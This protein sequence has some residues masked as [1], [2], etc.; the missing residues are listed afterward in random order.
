MNKTLLI[1]SIAPP[2]NDLNIIDT[3]KY[4][5]LSLCINSWE[6]SG[7]DIV[8]V[9]S[10]QEISNL[11]KL[12]TNVK[13]AEAF[14][15]TYS[16]NKRNLVYISDALHY[17]RTSNYKRIAICNGDVLIT[18]NLKSLE[19]DLNSNNFYFSHRINIDNIESTE[20]NIFTGI[21]YFNASKSIIDSMPDTYFTF[22]L[23]WWDYWYPY[24]VKSNGGKIIQLVNSVSN[25]VLL[26]K[27]HNDAWNPKDLCLMGK[28]FFDL[29]GT[30]GL[31]N[32]RSNGLEYMYDDPSFKLNNQIVLFY[33]EMAR[34]VCKFLADNASSL[35][36]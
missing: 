17:A 22:G 32:I 1:T 31:I 10:A 35:K 23:P 14:R 13:F 11:S 8:S 34:N 36:I 3:D 29:V 28:H 12:F 25:P 20:G 21:D 33:S 24:F 5:W 19:Y 4:T 27:I 16:I 15:T 7:H 9:N 6:K 26:H 18:G 2:L 30:D